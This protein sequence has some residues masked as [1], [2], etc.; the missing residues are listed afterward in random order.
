LYRVWRDR[1]IRDSSTRDLAEALL[2]SRDVRSKASKA[3]GVTLDLYAA[4]ECEDAMKAL[5]S[6]KQHG[7]KRATIA[8]GRFWNK[9]GCGDNKLVDCWPCLR[10]NDLLKDAAAA[11]RKKKSP[12]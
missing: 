11:A 8:M 1:R 10:T 3:L 4:E 6:A 12:L 2:Y 5:Q 9:R 7:D